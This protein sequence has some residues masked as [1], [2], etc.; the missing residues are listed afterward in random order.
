MKV[1]MPFKQRNQAKFYNRNDLQ[2]VICSQ[3]IDNYNLKTMLKLLFLTQII[4][5]GLWFQV[6]LSNINSFQACP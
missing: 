2:T 6:F 4:C 5:T 3:E 1:D